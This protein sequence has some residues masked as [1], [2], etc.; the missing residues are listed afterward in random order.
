MEGR[1]PENIEIELRK[2]GCL[3]ACVPRDNAPPE[4]SLGTNTEVFQIG[5]VLLL[6]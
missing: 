5:K 4:Y 2:V 1:T 3:I 6:Q